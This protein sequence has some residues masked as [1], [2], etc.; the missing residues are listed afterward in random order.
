VRKTPASDAAILHTDDFLD[1]LTSEVEVAAVLFSVEFGITTLLE[2]IFDTTGG[3]VTGSFSVRH[4]VSLSADLLMLESVLQGMVV[5]CMLCLAV[6]QVRTFL[7]FKEEFHLSPGYASAVGQPL[8]ILRALQS[9]MREYN[10]PLV[11]YALDV[12]IQV[13][14]GAFLLAIFLDMKLAG[15]ETERLIWQ[16][17]DLQWSGGQH[18]AREVLGEYV[19]T[20]ND[21]DDHANYTKGLEDFGMILC[22]VMLVR[23]VIAT[24]AHPRTSLV[25]STL[26]RALGDLLHFG[27]IAMLICWSLSVI[28]AWRYGNEMG[29]MGSMTDAVMM[30]LEAFFDP[31]SSLFQPDRAALD[32]S[33]NYY[34]FFVWTIYSFF[35]LNFVLAIILESYARVMNDISVSEVD[36]DLLR[37]MASVL[38]ARVLRQRL[39]WPDA[40]QV[41]HALQQSERPVVTA[42]YL[43]DL[44]G[45]RSI[46]A[47]LTF[48]DYYRG[49]DFLAAQEGGGPAKEDNTALQL[50]MVGRRV[51]DLEPWTRAMDTR[52]ETV[53]QGLGSVAGNVAVLDRRF[54][55]VEADLQVIK[56]LLLNSA[57]TPPAEVE[58]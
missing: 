8:Q 51:A 35:L 14:I 29:E 50:E 21:I 13:L 27:I 20:L 57:R 33:W 28:G 52:I 42:E 7:L 25:T 56:S 40:M 19:E 55:A 10:G 37:D 54:S 18:S 24:E 4:Y 45:F 23:M 3:R 58:I 16:L 38:K 11:V 15:P 6:D 34:S 26:M 9:F 47:A 44:V 41:V 12:S 36:Q 49:F 5:F 48:F 1:S 53:T 2:V 46:K 17:L 30:Q 32:P 22:V 43:R 31:P 39:G